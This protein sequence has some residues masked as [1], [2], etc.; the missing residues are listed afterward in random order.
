MGEDEMTSHADFKKEIEIAKAFCA[1]ISY[2]GNI[3]PEPA[4][5]DEDDGNDEEDEDGASEDDRE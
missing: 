1:S 3:R 2:A 5:A 4:P